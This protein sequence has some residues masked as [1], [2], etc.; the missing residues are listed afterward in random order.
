[1]IKSTKVAQN[2]S[3]SILEPSDFWGPQRGPQTPDL[4]LSLTYF[5]QVRKSGISTETLFGGGILFCNMNSFIGT[6][7]EYQP[8]KVKINWGI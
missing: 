6:A 1:M 3:L 8:E 5:P 7:C 4:Y 2:A